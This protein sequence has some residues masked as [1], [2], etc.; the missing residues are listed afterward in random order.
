MNAASPIARRVKVAAAVVAL[1]MAIHPLSGCQPQGGETRTQQAP[2][3]TSQTPGGPGTPAS[4]A[5]VEPARL[6]TALP[7]ATPREA[8][9]GRPEDEDYDQLK[10]Q[11]QETPLPT[12]ENITKDK[13]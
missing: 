11:A 5:P 1:L 2:T 3:T 4:P 13:P 10:K 7:P 8:P 12:H 9:I 6:P